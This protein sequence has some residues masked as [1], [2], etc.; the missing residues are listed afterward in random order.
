MRAY[1]NIQVIGTHNSY[2]VQPRPA[3]LALISSIDK[4]TAL[5]MEYTHRP[6]GD[7]LAQLGMR[8]LELD[9][10]ADPNGGLYASPLGDIVV[11]GGSGVRPE[12]KAPGLKVLHAQDIDYDS[13]CRTFKA[14]LGDILAWSNA[15]PTHV[16]LMIQIEAKD[17]PLQLPPGVQLPRAPITPVKFTADQL[18]TID[19]EILAVIPRAKILTPDDVRGTHA[20]LE[21]AILTDGWPALDA[22]RGRIFFTLDN[23]DQ[24]RTDYIAGHASLAGRVLF[25]SSDPGTPEAA[26]V[27]LNDPT[28]DYEKIQRLVGRGYIVRTRADDNTV[29]ARTVNTQRRTLALGSGAQFVSTDYPEADP[30]SGKYRV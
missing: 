4:N 17:D 30:F 26:F 15:N 27:K 21:E 14:C 16:P 24:K 5:A 1:N 2:H 23:T 19:T 11:P 22:V 7:Q 12:M 10:F 29:E 18:D 13:R 28:T 6:L 25:T 8:Q 9:V 20:T 3:L